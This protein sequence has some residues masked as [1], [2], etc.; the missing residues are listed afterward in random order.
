MFVI[1]L[2]FFVLF[3]ARACVLLLLFNNVYFV[4][5]NEITLAATSHIIKLIH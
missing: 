2:F 5:L 3:F 1:V 4:P